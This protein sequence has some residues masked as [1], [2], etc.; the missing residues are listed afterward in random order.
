MNNPVCW[1][2]GFELYPHPPGCTGH[3]IFELLRSRRP[4]IFRGNYLQ[5]FER[6]NLV[7]GPVFDRRAARDRAQELYA[8]LWGSRRTVVLFGR[9][10]V[11]AFDIPP[12]LVHPQE[13]GGVTWRQLPHPSGRNLWYNDYDNRRIAAMLLEELY[14]EATEDA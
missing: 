4:E 9:E 5:A 14:V 12:V 2:P 3:R 7:I 1:K 11:R 8:E 13:I 6:Q 10:V